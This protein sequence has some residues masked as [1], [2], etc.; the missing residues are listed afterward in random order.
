MRA[1]EVYL[2]KGIER[3]K[4][5]PAGGWFLLFVAVQIGFGARGVRWNELQMPFTCVLCGAL[6]REVFE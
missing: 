3:L 4:Q 2:G 6:D 5:K 1:V